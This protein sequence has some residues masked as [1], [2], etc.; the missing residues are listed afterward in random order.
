MCK[1]QRPRGDSARFLRDQIEQVQDDR[2]RAG[3]RREEDA[4]DNTE[5]ES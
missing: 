1:C 3:R 5:E 4:A 2:I